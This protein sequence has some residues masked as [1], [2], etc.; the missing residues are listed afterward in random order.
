M[1]DL[2]S[3]FVTLG[4]LWVAGNRDDFR[5]FTGGETGRGLVLGGV[6]AASAEWA[7]TQLTNATG[8]S[9]TLGP[10][11]AQALAGAAVSAGGRKVDADRFTNPVARGIMY[12]AAQQAASQ[13]GLSA[14]QLFGDLTGGGGGGGTGGGGGG[15]TGGGGVAEVP[16]VAQHNDPS[17]AHNRGG[18]VF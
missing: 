10:E 6:G 11:L 12:N 7:G 14:G 9:G 17:P 3:P 4:A 15:N 2:S 16:Q 8:M 5:K 13:A 18:M 1:P